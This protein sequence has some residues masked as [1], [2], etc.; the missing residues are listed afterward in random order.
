[1]KEMT[2]AEKQET[3]ETNELLVS[4][5]EQWQELTEYQTNVANIKRYASDLQTCLAVKQIEKDV[6]TNDMCLQSLLNG[7]SLHQANLSC[8]IDTGLKTTTTSI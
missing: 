8:K 7:D 5:D 2:E 6:E 3:E 1:M 4:L